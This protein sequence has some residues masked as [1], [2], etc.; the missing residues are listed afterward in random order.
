MKLLVLMRDDSRLMHS[1]F[2]YSR[3]IFHLGSSIGE[4]SSHMVA[5]KSDVQNEIVKNK[6]GALYPL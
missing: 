1:E 2:R 5:S 3:P 6:K 4:I